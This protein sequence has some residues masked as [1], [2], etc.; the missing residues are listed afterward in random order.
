MS[1]TFRQYFVKKKK[2][3]I[4]R[5][6]YAD[7]FKIGFE[8]DCGNVDNYFFLRTIG[9]NSL[10]IK[11]SAKIRTTV[12]SDRRADTYENILPMHSMN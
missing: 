10:K 1:M 11:R 3:T 12:H 8:I 6:G 5:Y 4:R 7:R 9:R 2:K